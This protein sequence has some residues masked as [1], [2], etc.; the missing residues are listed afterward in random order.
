MRDSPADLILYI[1]GSIVLLFSLVLVLV[2]IRLQREARRNQ[3]DIEWLQVQLKRALTQINSNNP[4]EILAGLQTISVLNDP[5][6]RLQALSRLSALLASA[7]ESVAEQAKA[8][9]EKI[10][11]AALSRAAGAR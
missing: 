2:A 3:G 7:N 4:D 1:V 5:A 9:V 10:S 6:A 8:T 11:T